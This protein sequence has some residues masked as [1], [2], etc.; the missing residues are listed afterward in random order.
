MV[1]PFRLLPRGNG[2]FGPLLDGFGL[3]RDRSLPGGLGAIGFLHSGSPGLFAGLTAVCCLAK[4]LGD[5]HIQCHQ[6]G[7]YESCVFHDFPFL[8]LIHRYLEK[9]KISAKNGSVSFTRQGT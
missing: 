4:T 5:A 3:R 2:W 8:A 9:I 6:H 7:G 1:T